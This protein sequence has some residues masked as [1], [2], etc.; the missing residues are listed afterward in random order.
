MSVSDRIF[1]RLTRPKAGGDKPFLPPGYIIEPKYNGWR[2]GIIKGKAYTRHG[3]PYPANWKEQ[4]LIERVGR[5]YPD[6]SFDGEFMGRR[7]GH[8]YLMLFDIIDDDM[9]WQERKDK[10]NGLHFQPFDVTKPW[11]AEGK[12]CRSPFWRS[13]VDDVYKLLKMSNDFDCDK[14]KET[15]E[16]VV[17]KKISTVYAMN[18]WI[19]FRFDQYIN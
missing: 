18:D 4:E 7:G 5:T 10:L 16:G 9:I 11:K 2:V 1:I 19:K 17:I 13:G 6:L 15:Y 14:G 3:D 8:T 12:I